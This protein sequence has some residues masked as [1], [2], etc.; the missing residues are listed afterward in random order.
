MSRYGFFSTQKLYY[1][2]Y[3]CTTIL[4]ALDNPCWYIVWVIFYATSSCEYLFLKW[5]YSSIR[6]QS[7]TIFV[8]ID[9][10]ISSKQEKL[11]HSS[12]WLLILRHSA[13]Q[14]ASRTTPDRTQI[15][16]LVAVA[17]SVLSINCNFSKYVF[18]KHKTAVC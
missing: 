14:S 10:I 4:W 15:P 9:T 1:S 8:N 16:Q 2:L 12:N 17:K 18:S 7:M 3:I 5:Q 6:P 13:H 11:I